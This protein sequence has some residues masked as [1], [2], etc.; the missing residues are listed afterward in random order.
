MNISS[1]FAILD[2]KKGRAELAKYFKGNN[3]AL[4]VTIEAEIFNQHSKDD[5]FSIEFGLIVKKV[6]VK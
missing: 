5:G 4:K 2:V 1:D 3:P 6:T